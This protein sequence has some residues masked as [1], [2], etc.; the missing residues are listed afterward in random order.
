MKIS[1]FNSLYL[2]PYLLYNIKL[3]IFWQ[4][5]SSSLKWCIAL[6]SNL[7]FKI[8]LFSTKTRSNVY[9]SH[10]ICKRALQAFRI[11]KLHCSNMIRSWDITVQTLQNSTLFSLK[12]TNLNISYQNNVNCFWFPSKEH[13]KGWYIAIYSILSPL[14]G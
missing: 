3:Y 10:I 1:T 8:I 5:R 13:F 9:I 2:S 7:N 12:N 6:Y 14:F 4:L 11:Y